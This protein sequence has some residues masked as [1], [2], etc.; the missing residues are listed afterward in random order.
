[1]QATASGTQL[2]T[3]IDAFD[4]TFRLLLTFHRSRGAVSDDAR[5]NG[6]CIFFLE[7]LKQNKYVYSFRILGNFGVFSQLETL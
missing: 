5:K 3:T 7:F 2:L 6:D 1:M 4:T